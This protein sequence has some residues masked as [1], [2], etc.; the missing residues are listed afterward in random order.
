MSSSARFW[1]VAL[2]HFE[3]FVESPEVQ[4]VASNRHQGRQVQSEIRE[5]QQKADDEIAELKRRAVAQRGDLKGI[6]DQITILTSRIDSLQ[7]LTP[8][9]SAAPATALSAARAVQ[10]APGNPSAGPN[11]K[12][13]FL[14]EAHQ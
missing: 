7:S 14:S 2:G 12:G 8:L 9:P 13:L 11:E 6:L 1:R 5:A 4:E 3:Q 10:A